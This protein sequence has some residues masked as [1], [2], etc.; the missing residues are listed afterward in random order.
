MSIDGLGEDLHSWW[1]LAELPEVL[2]HI[3]IS[4]L[5]HQQSQLLLIGHNQTHREVLIALGAD[6][7]LYGEILQVDKRICSRWAVDYAYIMAVGSLLT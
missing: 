6:A 3:T 5:L 1:I 2:W 4:S 7:H